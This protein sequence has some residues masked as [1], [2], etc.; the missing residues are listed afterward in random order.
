MNKQDYLRLIKQQLNQ[1]D[2]DTSLDIMTQILR[3]FD[4][5]A[6]KGYS[7]REIIEQLGNPSKL[8]LSYQNSSAEIMAPKLKVHE[9]VR[10]EVTESVPAEEEGTVVVPLASEVEQDTVQSGGTGNS[11][12]IVRFLLGLMIGLPILLVLF[13]VALAGMAAAAFAFLQ[14]LIMTFDLPYQIW[15]FPFNIREDFS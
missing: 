15:Q 4:E 9:E 8:I 13:S 12:A 7:E 3:T 2:T 10:V 1:M 14:G 5:K 11:G 6:A